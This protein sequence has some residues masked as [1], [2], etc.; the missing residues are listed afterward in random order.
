MQQ[1]VEDNVSSPGATNGG[2]ARI[3]K[4]GDDQEKRISERRILKI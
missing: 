2:G 4:L 1:I 3:G